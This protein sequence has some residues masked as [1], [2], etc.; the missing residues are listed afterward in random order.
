VSKIFTIAMFKSFVKDNDSNKTC[1]YVHDL[2]VH[3]AS[4]SATL[5]ELSPQNKIP[6]LTSISPRFYHWFL[7]KMVLL[8]VVHP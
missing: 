5:H 2:V 4:F 8:K 7:R 6:I 3:Q 1:T